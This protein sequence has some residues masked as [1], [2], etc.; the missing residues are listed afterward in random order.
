MGRGPDRGIPSR[1][2]PQRGGCA[3][4][5]PAA[6]VPRPAARL[7]HAGDRGPRSSTSDSTPSC[8][9]VADAVRLAGDARVR[10]RR[11]AGDRAWRFSTAR[12]LVAPSA[13][14]SVSCIRGCSGGS[15]RV[16]AWASAAR[17]I[18]GTT[19]PGGSSRPRT[20]LTTARSPSGRRRPRAPRDHPASVGHQPDV[21]G[22]VVRR[23]ADSPQTPARPH[24][25][26]AGRARDP[27]IIVGDGELKA[28]AARAARRSAYRRR[29]RDSSTR[30][31]SPTPTRPPTCSCCRPVAT[32]HGAWSSMKRWPAACR[33]WFRTQRGAS[34][35]SFVMVR[36][37]TRLPEGDIDDL[38]Q[39]L[40]YLVD[41]PA[42]RPA[43][44][45]RRPRASRRTRRAA[46]A[47]GVLSA[48]EAAAGRAPW[49]C[50][51]PAKRGAAAPPSAANTIAAAAR[52]R[53]HDRPG[54]MVL[55]P[56][57]PVAAHH[58]AG[59]DR[60]VRDVTAYE[61]DSLWI[62]AGLALTVLDRRFTRRSRCPRY[63]GSRA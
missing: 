51:H 59:R 39:I 20:S 40:T 23:Q 14:S 41:H 61:H 46:A 42:R 35:I 57:V 37:D 52:N 16:S 6:A 9:W 10:G 13:C 25:R 30:R 1:L 26:G 33:R 50:N 32:R 17:S 34:P 18:S 3:P 36:R 56:G 28:N 22:G 24:S 47:A 38:R 63:R 31:R 27:L 53:H 2:A 45:R 43:W 55:R 5:N 21:N 8:S 54:P 48:A 29:S 7:R 49:P 44:G 11:D 4:P 15:R 62:G 19:A 60:A 12:R 58:H